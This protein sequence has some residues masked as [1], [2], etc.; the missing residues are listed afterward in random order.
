MYICVQVYLLLQKKI[1]D[2]SHFTKSNSVPNSYHSE[3]GN[4]RTRCRN[5]VKKSG[6]LFCLSQ[7]PMGS[8]ACAG[9]W[10]SQFASVCKKNEEKEDCCHRTSIAKTINFKQWISISCKTRPL[11]FNWVLNTAGNQQQLGICYCHLL[12][13][14][15]SNNVSWW[16]VRIAQVKRLNGSIHSCVL[17]C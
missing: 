6:Y 3:K 5:D 4:R 14:L 16:G 12:W 2:W 8:N 15:K 13:N 9:Q 10:P 7:E 11:L 1:R 17:K